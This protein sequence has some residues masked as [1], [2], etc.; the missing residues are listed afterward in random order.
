MPS[1]NE[2]SLKTLH[3]PLEVLKNKAGNALKDSLVFLQA[4]YRQKEAKIEIE[5]QK[6]EMENMK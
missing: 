4:R 3:P 6:K 5:N 2:G 1:D